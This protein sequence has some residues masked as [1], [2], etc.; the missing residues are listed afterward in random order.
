[1]SQRHEEFE[2][3][4]NYDTL[5]EV[6]DIFREYYVD[7][8]NVSDDDLIYGA[9]RGMMEAVDDPGHT[10][11]FDPE[12]E[13]E[14]AESRASEFVGIGVRIDVET[15]PPTVIEPFADSPALEAGILPG[16]EILAVDGVPWDLLPEID[17]FLD[18][19]SGDEGT[20]VV[21]QLRHVN[22]VEPYE[23]TITRAPI[24]NVTV[25]WVMLPDDIV[26]L[27]I[28]AFNEGTGQ[29]LIAALQ[30]AKAL[31]AEGLILDLR[32]NAGGLVVE[33]L[34]VEAQFM[35]PGTVA[36]IGVD[37][38]GEETPFL[39]P[40]ELEL[41]TGETVDLAEGEWREQPMVVLI[42]ENTASAGESV[43]GS[44][45]GNDRTIT[46]G[47]TTVGLGTT[48]YQFP[49][50]DGSMVQVSFEIWLTPDGISIWRTGLDP[51]VQVSNEPDAQLL[52]PAMYA[53]QV[54]PDDEFAQ[55]EDAQLLA[56]YE[57]VMEQMEED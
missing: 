24:P 36:F 10:A 27:R 40:E 4:E 20:E 38:D 57:D 51:I 29:E 53:D 23:V 54:I 21:I 28:S 11:F 7:N 26:W 44:L 18:L 2:D 6:Y 9:A 47:E 50:D 52:F 32:G 33:E 45:A 43:S 31:G 12:E 5:V 3:L 34:H 30:E 17:D 39:I 41:T 49:L 56:G 19:I 35:E 48:V 16:D 25:T 15:L 42:D 46:I 1:G 14:R 8:E 22:E 37:A 13:Q 55:T